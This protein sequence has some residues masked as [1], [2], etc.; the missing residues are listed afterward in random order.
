MNA[1]LSRSRAASGMLFMLTLLWAFTHGRAA[2]PDDAEARRALNAKLV[3]LSRTHP[4]PI[5]QIRENLDEAGAV[6]MKLEV[7][8]LAA[9]QSAL[10]YSTSKARDG[11]PA[12]TGSFGIV[13]GWHCTLT[14]NGRI[15]LGE[16]A[17]R[18]MAVI[19][20]TLE[21]LTLENLLSP[22]IEFA[23]NMLSRPNFAVDN[24]AMA[25]PLIALV[26]RTDFA[27]IIET[28][29]I[30]W[31]QDNLKYVGTVAPDGLIKELEVYVG[32]VKRIVVSTRYDDAVVLPPELAYYRGRD[33]KKVY[34]DL[35]PAPRPDK[36][37][38]KSFGISWKL[39]DGRIIVLSVAAHSPAARQGLVPGMTIQM[40]N[41]IDLSNLDTEATRALFAGD[42]C[43]LEAMSP[44]GQPRTFELQKS[45]PES[46][47]E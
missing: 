7:R 2:D 43:R 44:D 14:A 45:V 40:V 35:A 38:V 20:D 5:V 11:E 1:R 46:W 13:S 16:A 21:Y 33:G 6:L 36:D 10:I 32:N 17:K 28:G 39:E 24:P 30:D 22:R 37:G 34:L 4:R 29:K 27:R 18:H 42:V 25:A 19:D 23:R 9:Q 31:W 47:K 12:R 8:L 3:E 26:T 41:G 15:T